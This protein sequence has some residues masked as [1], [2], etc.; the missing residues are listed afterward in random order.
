MAETIRLLVRGLLVEGLLVER[1]LVEGL[2]VD[3]LLVDR[4]LVDRLLVDR[5]LVEGLLV[6]ELLVE[7][8]LVEGLLGPRLTRTKSSSSLF[9]SASSLFFPSSHTILADFSSS[10]TVKKWK[11]VIKTFFIKEY[12]NEF[13]T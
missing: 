5:L 13:A 1:L 11:H 8:L 6:E 9:L 10:A 3:R 7:R 4:L 12:Q 2:L